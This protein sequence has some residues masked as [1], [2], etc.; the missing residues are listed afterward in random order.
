MHKALR[1]VL[2][3]SWITLVGGVWATA[4]GSAEDINGVAGGNGNGGGAA[5]GNGGGSATGNGGSLNLGGNT[6]DDG[7]LTPDASCA[8]VSKTADQIPLSMYLMQ[9]RS[10]SMQ[11]SKWSDVNTAL[12]QFVN[13]PGSAGI[14]IALQYFPG[15][16]QCNGSGYDT[17]AVPMGSLPGNANAIIQSLQST[18]PSGNTPME[19]GLSGVVN[20]CKQYA[21]QNPQEKTIAVLVTDGEPNGCNE[22]PNYLAGICG[23][24]FSTNPSI[25]VF[26]MGMQG[27][28][29]GTLNAFAQAGGTGT[30]YDISNGGA[31]AFLAALQ[32]IAGSVLACDYI[33]PT[34]DAGIIDPNKVVVKYT[35]S[36]GTAQDLPQVSDASQC[37][38]GG[39]FYY[40]NPTNPTKI[41]LC[42]DTCTTAQAD[43]GGHIDV[44]LG[45]AI[46][47]PT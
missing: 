13:D 40:D 20:F 30:A 4:C 38:P 26:V 11:G 24:S 45:C 25:L 44:L 1:S 47:P 17:P 5:H 34:T 14:K 2:A 33:M 35:S 19:G 39:G 41:S 43:T 6:G 31:G 29:F 36:S 12:Q 16:G 42:P 3:L 9:D 10:G 32:A 27:A 23:T 8:S 28:N 37:G 46:G 21:G 18:S 15:N 22:D 7:S